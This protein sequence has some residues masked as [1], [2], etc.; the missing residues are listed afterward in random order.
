[1]SSRNPQRAR[2]KKRPSQAAP[3][4]IGPILVGVVVLVV[5]GGGVWSFLNSRGPTTL[6]EPNVAASTGQP[7]GDGASVAGQSVPAFG[8]S[9]TPAVSRA[10]VTKPVSG[11]GLDQHVMDLQGARSDVP[12]NN[13]ITDLLEYLR[14]PIIAQSA[15]DWP[16]SVDQGPFPL[17]PAGPK[18]KPKRLVIPDERFNLRNQSVIFPV[19]PS[20]CVAL[21]RN[22]TA[23]GGRLFVN[24]LTGEEIGRLVGRLELSDFDSHFALSPDGTLFAGIGAPSGG[25]SAI[26]WFDTATGKLTKTAQIPIGTRVDWLAAPS[27]THLVIG[28]GWD[29]ELHVLDTRTGKVLYTRPTRADNLN[30][31]IAFSPG[32]RY[33]VQGLELPDDGFA[34][35]WWDIATGDTVLTQVLPFDAYR[36][37]LSKFGGLRFSADGSQFAAMLQ[38]GTAGVIY[39]WDVATGRPVEQFV[40]EET[41]VKFGT[42][43]SGDVGGTP[44]EFFPGSD[45]LLIFEHAVLDRKT[46][47]LQGRIPE[48]SITVYNSRRALSGAIVS[49]IDV[50]QQNIGMLAF[51]LPE[52]F[53]P[54]DEQPRRIE[55]PTGTEALG[56]TFVALGESKP[57]DPASGTKVRPVDS[58]WKLTVSAEPAADWATSIPLHGAS[59]QLRSLVMS[60]GPTATMLTLGAKRREPLSI[61]TASTS[62][63][64]V[65]AARKRLLKD[66]S[67][68]DGAKTA[69][70]SWL[71]VYDGTS[72]A[73]SG[74][75]A[76][77]FDAEL[78]DVSPDGKN[79]V[80][81]TWQPS[82]D[83]NSGLAER[84][85]GID[86]VTGSMIADVTLPQGDGDQIL[87]SGS[88]AGTGQLATIDSTGTMT[89]WNWPALNPA[90]QV[91][92][93]QQTCLMPGGSVIGYADGNDWWFLET[94]TG[95]AVGKLSGTG[96]V[97][98]AAVS[99]AGDKIALLR[100]LAD[101]PHL[102]VH[103][104]ATG[105][106]VKDFIAPAS[107]GPVAWCDENTILLGNLALFDLRREAVAWT[108]PP[109]FWARHLPRHVAGRHWWVSTFGHEA[110][111]TS[112]S[113]PGEKLAGLIADS[114]S[115]SPF[116][117]QPGTAVKLE[118]SF[119][120]NDKRPGFEKQV[121][122]QISAVLARRGWKIDPKSNIRLHISLFESEVT[123]NAGST[124]T[125]PKTGQRV[126][127]TRTAK[128]PSTT[129]HAAIRD[130]GTSAWSRDRYF[131]GPRPADWPEPPK[132][133]G[134]ADDPTRMTVS[135]PWQSL[136]DEIQAVGQ[137]LPAVVL[138][139]EAA[140]GAGKT[141]WSDLIQ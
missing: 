11:W 97:A 49:V 127:Q 112:V 61:A 68:E 72:G 117:V 90:Y 75:L 6:S 41:P 19:S 121:R 42:G 12:L 113:L 36:I 74:E 120:D 137:W 101:G 84:L 32:G 40:L 82:A 119:S 20:P 125:D 45:R 141:T 109:D 122:D 26:S 57:V 135:D 133:N 22:E 47:G 107:N 79:A 78:L 7:P 25:T 99:S 24:L 14:R 87:I 134:T 18:K 9:V 106:L 1:M 96:R 89:V 92:S 62:L 114:A 23:E 50:G 34:L 53:E 35:E 91:D 8:Q 15:D 136:N 59:T 116:L 128:I 48:S 80:L 56:R 104:L 126:S 130:G 28:D 129:M 16:I 4:A 140:Q 85:V 95:A 131:T 123:A 2:G 43:F 10:S 55:L 27:A 37:W 93:V 52:K 71:S 39:I 69:V 118:V 115:K 31:A 110:K 94:A 103:D 51:E 13:I 44:L 30:R 63:D 5:L 81:L 70:R 65:F 46:G 132:R 105:T 86:V 58:G 98:A 124:F 139:P 33:G 64:Q 83:G 108:I 17:D 100:D 111:V 73:F 102:S 38:V 88:F 66:L 3:P 60:S 138:T 77:G 76:L 54:I 29:K 67:S 21:G